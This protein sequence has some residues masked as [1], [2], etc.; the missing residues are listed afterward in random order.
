MGA[1]HRRHFRSILLR[2]PVLADGAAG[3]GGP[4]FYGG[5]VAAV[6]VG[7]LPWRFDAKPLSKRLMTAKLA[8]A[9]GG[10]DCSGRIRPRKSLRHQSE[11]AIKLIAICADC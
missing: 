5:V 7:C 8:I 9:D 11:N 6:F 4:A 2:N 3:C 10:A 1:L